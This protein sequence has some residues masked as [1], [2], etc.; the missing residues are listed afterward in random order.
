MVEDSRAF[1]FKKGG[2]LCQPQFLLAWQAL[3]LTFC[4]QCLSFAVESLG[5]HE[6]DRSM[7]SGVTSSLSSVVESDASLDIDG[8]PSVERPISAA[9]HVDVVCLRIG[10]VIHPSLLV[11]L[12]FAPLTFLGLRVWMRIR[13]DALLVI[14]LLFGPIQPNRCPAGNF[15][16]FLLLFLCIRQYLTEVTEF[17]VQGITERLNG[18]KP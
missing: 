18:L 11:L 17:A 7:G 3:E 6:R 12:S 14:R 5:S 15:A 10:Y 16:L 8:V 2:L 13:E 9:G 4:S 1:S